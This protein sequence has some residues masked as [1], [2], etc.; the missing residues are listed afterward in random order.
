MEV[1]PSQGHAAT[2][3]GDDSFRGVFSSQTQAFIGFGATKRKVK[4]NFFVYAE[5]Q[6]DGTFLL[7]NLN[8]H[9]IPSG[10]S[11][12]VT[13]EELLKEYLPEPDVYMNKVV[14]MMRQV[15]ESVDAADAH[16][17]QGEL[18]SA[19][20]EYKNVL[21]IDEGH[22]RATFGLGLTYLDRDEADNANLVF[23]RILT[24]EAAFNEDHKHLFNE[25][26]MKMRRHKMYAQALRYYFK[27]YR[28][29]HTD[30]HLLYNIS[31]TYYDKGK[32][33]LAR[34]FLDMAL[35]INPSFDAS[36]GLLRAIEKKIE[37]EGSLSNDD[38]TLFEKF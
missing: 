20:F 17:A 10:K 26:G 1:V 24:L 12:R 3:T 30:D 35:A 22:I 11:R 5:E 15:R 37:Q 6:A 25:F 8:K 33:K 19:E 36:A 34:K 23:R 7:R 16:R 4:Q 18:M 21:R 28:L 2:Q 14:P 38:A 27:A 13:K 32:F 29:T 9:Y 31:R